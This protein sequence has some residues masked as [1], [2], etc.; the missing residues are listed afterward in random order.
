MPTQIRITM[1]TMITNNNLF[2]ILIINIF[3]T[4]FISNL[5]KLKTIFIKATD[6]FIIRTVI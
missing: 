4:Y 1:D 3:F 6:T 5:L 2:Y